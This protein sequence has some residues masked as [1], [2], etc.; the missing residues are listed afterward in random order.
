[1][2]MSGDAWQRMVTYDNVRL[3]MATNGDYGNVETR[4]C[5]VSTVPQTTTNSNHQIQRSNQ[6]IIRRKTIQKPG[7]NTISP[8]I[9]IYKSIATRHERRIT[10]ISEGNR[11]SF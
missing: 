2:A 6:N 8:I 3:C 4:H 9:E 5:L 1:M 10:R 11:G 7:K